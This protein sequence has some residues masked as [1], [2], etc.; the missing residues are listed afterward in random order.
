MQKAAQSRAK[1]CAPSPMERE[2]AFCPEFSARGWGSTFRGRSS[3]SQLG[4][5]PAQAQAPRMTGF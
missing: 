4:T 2:I 1:A 5:L 3:N